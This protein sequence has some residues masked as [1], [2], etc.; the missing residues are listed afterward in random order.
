MVT[1]LALARPG[2]LPRQAPRGRAARE[3]QLDR[4]TDHPGFGLTPQRLVQI[5]RIAEAGFP[6]E[7]CDLFEDL[8]ESDAHLRNLLEQ[9]CQAVAGKPWIVQAGGNTANDELVARVLA[10]ALR[11]LPVIE[12]FEHQLSVNRYGYA[13]T[14]LE[15]EPV[16]LDGRI[17]IAPVWFA[18]VP[19]RRFVL[20]TGS[21]ELRLLTDAQPNR[22]EPL[23]QG[24]WVVTRR[25]GVRVVRSGL[26]RT[27]AWYAL[28][29]RYS[30][31]DWVVY[32]EKF[33]I[34]LPLVTYDETTGEDA[35]DVAAEIVEKIGDDGGAVVPKGIE[36]DVIDASRTGDSSG[37][38][39]GLIAHCNREMSKLIN[40]S[41]LSNDNGDSGGASYSLG[42][43]HDGVRWEAVQYDAERL[44]ESF[45]RQVAAAFVAFNGLDAAPP[46]LKIQVVR[47]LQPRQRA[48]IA[49]QLRNELGIPLSVAQL[50]EELGFREPTNSA[51][52]V[53]GA[54][55]PA[56]ASAQQKDAA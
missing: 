2:A 36:V 31:R 48:A 19:A 28:Y 43:I 18:N 30:T 10:A 51:D 53:P 8:V 11:R 22:G 26:L 3:I 5:F 17:W 52:E 47:D 45:R 15:W 7:Q 44:Q 23:E 32:A 50:R 56:A 37:T 41:T 38:H 20:D 1:R 33:G 54:P 29:K 4:W 21:D 13:C 27:A 55:Q 16:V 40:G 24:K 46:L 35:K 25:P 9:R 6:R 34:P 49:V 39:G 14:E 12:F 42:E